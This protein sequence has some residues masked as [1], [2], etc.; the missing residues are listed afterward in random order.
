MSSY[1]KLVSDGKW[2]FPDY[3][4]KCPICKGKDCAV[5]FCFY[6]RKCRDSDGCYLK[7]EII[8]YRCRQKE[9]PPVGSDRTF[10]LLPACLIP[11][12]QTHINILQQML[13]LWLVTGKSIEDVLSCI[14]SACIGEWYPEAGC[15]YKIKSLFCESVLKLK[16][17]TFA[18]L[19]NIHRSPHTLHIKTF[20]QISNEYKYQAG[21]CTVSGPAGLALDHY[22]AQNGW[23]SNAYFLFGTSSQHRRQT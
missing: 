4:E 2:Q 18:F 15:L 10:S 17:T 14:S 19:K 8:R 6:S 12:R 1:I 9:T 3:S 20:L 11:Y 22:F 16:L 23:E 13:Y 5:I 21:D 7:I